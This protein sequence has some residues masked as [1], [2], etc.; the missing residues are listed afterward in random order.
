VHNVAI[1]GSDGFIGSNLRVH[2][3]KRLIKYVS[4]SRETPFVSNETAQRI[5]DQNISDIVFLATDLTPLRAETDREIVESELKGLTKTLEFLLDVLPSAN[6][7]FPSSGGTV[8]STSGIGKLESDPTEGVNAYGIYKAKCEQIVRMSSLSHVILRISNVYGNSQKIGR[9]QGVIAEWMHAARQKEK[10]VVVG[11]LDQ[12][13][14]FVYIE[15]LSRAVESAVGTK[16]INEVINIGSGCA[17]SLSE[18]IEIICDISGEP[19][20]IDQKEGR[21]FDIS[22][23]SLNIDKAHEILGWRPVVNISDGIKL[24]WGMV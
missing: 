24:I 3:D 13:R 18:L 23:I 17:T 9:G 16:N 15:D 1:I 6:F 2:F 7:I 19:L 22:H 8:Y 4:F 5:S 10:V 20:T 12:S 14:D 11:S 21:E